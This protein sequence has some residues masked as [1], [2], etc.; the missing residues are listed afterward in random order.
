MRSET[1]ILNSLLGVTI[2]LVSSAVLAQQTNAPAPAAARPLQPHRRP[3]R[4]VCRRVSASLCSRQKTRLRNSKPQMRGLVLRGPSQ[5]PASTQWR[6]CNLQRFSQPRT[7][8]PQVKARGRGV[9]YAA[10]LREP[11]SAPS[12]VMPERAPLSVRRPELSRVGLVSAMRRRK[13]NNR[14][15]RLRLMPRSRRRR[16]QHSR[17]PLLT[18]ASPRAWRVRATRLSKRPR[19]AR[20]PYPSICCTAVPNPRAGMEVPGLQ[21]RRAMRPRRPAPASSGLSVTRAGGRARQ[22]S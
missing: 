1:W 2:T 11:L 19:T 15:S 7:L 5:P 14:I 9:R 20:F 3:P 12:R 13:R 10:R 4:P 6:P 22:T 8:R 18:R 17:R 21:P 16:P